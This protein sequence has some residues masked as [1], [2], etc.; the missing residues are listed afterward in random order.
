MP[1]PRKGWVWSET[2]RAPESYTVAVDAALDRRGVLVTRG[3]GCDPW[4]L[5]LRGGV[6][7]CARI[8]MAVEDHGGGR[9]MVR[10][11]TWPKVGWATLSLITLLGLL[12]ALAAVDGAWVAAAAIALV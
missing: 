2:W 8:C 11:R 4:D 1:W 12:A 9:Q 7:G 6:L 3:G 5:E 10:F